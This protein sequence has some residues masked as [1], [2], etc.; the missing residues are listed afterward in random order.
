TRRPFR[1]FAWV[2]FRGRSGSRIPSRCRRGRSCSRW[3]TKGNWKLRPE[4]VARQGGRLL[5]EHYADGFALGVTR[6][7]VS[8]DLGQRT[9][10]SPSAAPAAEPRTPRPSRP[11]RHPAPAAPHTPRRHPAATPP[12]AGRTSPFP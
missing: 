3:G 11:R 6:G 8:V 2:A 7:Q 4:T 10:P 1:G 12:R 5:R 9:P